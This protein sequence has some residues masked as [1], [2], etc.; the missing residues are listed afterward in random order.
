MSVPQALSVYREVGEKIFGRKQKRALGGLNVFAARYKHQD[1][2]SVVNTIVLKHCKEHATG[3]CSA[4]RLLWTDMKHHN[5]D[6]HWHLCQA[7]VSL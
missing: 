1:V 2:Q 7:Y 3:T 6:N 5:V 4:D